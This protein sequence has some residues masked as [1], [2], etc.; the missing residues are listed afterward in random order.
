MKS[1]LYYSFITSSQEAKEEWWRKYEQIVN[2]WQ[3]NSIKYRLKYPGKMRINAQPIVFTR[4]NFPFSGKPG[5]LSSYIAGY[6]G[7]YEDL[8]VVIADIPEREREE[9]KMEF[10]DLFL[11]CPE[12]TFVFQCEN[13]IPSSSQTDAITNSPLVCEADRITDLSYLLS[14]N[15]LF[16]ASGLRA[17]IKENKLKKLKLCRNFEERRNVRNK[18]LALIV[19]EEAE[20]CLHNSYLFYASGYRCLPISSADLLK[21]IKKQGEIKYDVIARDFDLQ[22][23]DE[24]NESSE[25]YNTVDKIR[26]YHFDK[27]KKEWTDLINDKNDFWNKKDYD[28]GNVYIITQGYKRDGGELKIELT[29]D[30]K[31]TIHDNFLIAPGITKPVVGVYKAIKDGIPKVQESFNNSII[32]GNIQRTREG[33]DH[34]AAL[35]LYGIAF[36]LTQRAK[37]YYN[38]GKYILSAILSQEAIDILDGYHTALSVQSYHLYAI[39]ENAIAMNVIG[40]DEDELAEDCKIRIEK[41]KKEVE[42]LIQGTEFEKINI[43][44]QIYSDCRLMCKEKEHFKSEDVFISEMAYLNE[45]G[46]VY[47]W[48]RDIA[49]WTKKLFSNVNKRK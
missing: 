2:T 22:F 12:I 32:Q 35:D 3:E 25:N 10:C 19:D 48:F 47:T 44:N 43:L 40:G 31:I 1:I 8:I 37:R 11:S 21:R 45:G 14:F 39:S 13:C 16:D 42:T 15:S 30:T 9:L 6:D 7:P 17:A 46:T 27:S 33:G 41:I 38:E 24:E 36:P 20:Q 28:S 4:N 5:E 26:G 18:S 49:L 29:K 23:E 34:S